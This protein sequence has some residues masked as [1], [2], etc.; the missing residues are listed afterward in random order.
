MGDAVSF[1]SSSFDDALSSGDKSFRVAANTTVNASIMT[2]NIETTVS[3]YNG[4]FENLP[5]FL[6]VWSGKNFT[7]SGSM[8]NLWYAQQANST[9][10]G[11]Y[12]S[13]P[14]RDWSYD[15]DLDDP[16]K[17]PPESPVV[18]IFQRTGW[19]QSDIGYA[20]VND[21]VAD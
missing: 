18:R 12:Y 8:V 16:T 14:I 2:G 3:D 5:R 6:E 21:A 9:W 19:S 10:N 13:P 15:T 1:L 17:L 4:G 11:T 7:W 20:N